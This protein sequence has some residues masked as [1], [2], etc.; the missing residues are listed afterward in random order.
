MV[1]LKTSSMAGAGLG[2]LRVLD[3][4]MVGAYSTVRTGSDFGVNLNLS[5]L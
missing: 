1:R 4:R 3:R 5:Y 2:E